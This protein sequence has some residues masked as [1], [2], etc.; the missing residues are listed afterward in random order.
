MATPEKSPRASPRT[1]ELLTRDAFF[2]ISGPQLGRGEH[3][4][5]KTLANKLACGPHSCEI[6]VR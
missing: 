5:L 2:W 4:R 3:L 6:H 1:N